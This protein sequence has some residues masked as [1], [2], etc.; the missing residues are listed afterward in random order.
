M[1][2]AIIGTFVALSFFLF[3]IVRVEGII[4]SLMLLALVNILQITFFVLDNHFT[5]LRNSSVRSSKK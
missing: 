4:A 2:I 1:I 3:F 5:E